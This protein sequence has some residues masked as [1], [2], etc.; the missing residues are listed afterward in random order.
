MS[1]TGMT[2]AGGSSQLAEIQAPVKAGLEHVSQ[3]IWRIVAEDFPLIEG[4]NQHL[5]GMKGKMFRPTLLLLANQVEERP[6]PRATTIAAAL[7]LIHLGTLVHDDAVDH[8]VLRRGMP[9]VN[10]LFSH[11][12]SV[13][14]GDFLYTR[15]LRELVR[16]GDMEL[17]RVLTEASNQM[18]MG[19]MRQLA[20][21]D[22]LSFTEDDYDQLI[23]AKT[24]SLMGAATELG[25][26]VGAPRH[27]A[28]LARFGLRLGMAFQV[29]DDLLDYT[30]TS[31]VTGKPAG[32]DLREHKVTIPLIAALREMS[33]AARAVVEELFATAEP[34]DE[35]VAA[36][37]GIVTE[38]GGLEYARRKGD[39]FVV[40]AEEALADLPETPARA[41]LTETIAYVLDRRS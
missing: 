20:A 38:H 22:R 5:M 31:D 41:A 11:Q 37:V 12:I 3:E 34:T 27:R 33:P 35:Q 30:A 7:E 14:M 13:I 1:G 40:D 2:A 24:A 26:L 28:R 23:M 19:E 8:S 17:L 6:D 25:A 9:T 15:A 18:T 39:A 36:V 21:F 16:M 32:L 29:A 4:V 10:A